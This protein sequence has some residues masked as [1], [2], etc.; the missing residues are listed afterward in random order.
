MCGSESLIT[1]NDVQRG[2]LV[3][4]KCHFLTTT[5]LVLPKLWSVPLEA[6]VNGNGSGSHRV[7][8]P[9]KEPRHR[10]IQ[11]LT[12]FPL[13]VSSYQIVRPRI[14]VEGDFKPK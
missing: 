3:R 11:G 6:E 10:Q 12:G 4:L 9:R 13:L 1:V 8:R 7:D 14:D 5:L 2:S